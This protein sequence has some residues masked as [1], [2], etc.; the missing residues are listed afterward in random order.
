MEATLIHAKKIAEYRAA[1]AS[2]M[3]W[4]EQAPNEA[5]VQRWRNLAED[6]T[7]MADNLERSENP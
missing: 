3:Q 1:A 6:W 5:M 7:R 2:C 4:A